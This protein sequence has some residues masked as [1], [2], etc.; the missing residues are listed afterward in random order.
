MGQVELRYLCHPA[1]VAQGRPQPRISA[2]VID[3]QMNGLVLTRVVGAQ[4]G[5]KYGLMAV[6]ELKALQKGKAKP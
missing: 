3:T 1:S 5:Q 6:R 4:I 2:R